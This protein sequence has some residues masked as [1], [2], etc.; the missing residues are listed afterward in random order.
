VA[1]RA[2]RV[3]CCDIDGVEHTVDVTAETLYEAV[4]MGL[5]ALRDNEWTADFGHGQTTITVVARHPEVEHKVR[6]RDFESWLQS[7]ARSPAEMIL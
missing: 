1:L 7:A 2:C 4:A 5:A 3:T 6:M